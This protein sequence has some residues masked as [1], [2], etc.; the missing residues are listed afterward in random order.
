LFETQRKA[1]ANFRSEMHYKLAT[2]LS[3]TG[4]FHYRYQTVSICPEAESAQNGSIM[5]A[6]NQAFYLAD[7]KGNNAMLFPI[8]HSIC[9]AVSFCYEAR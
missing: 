7:R 1:S 6:G 8:V 5:K 9:S 2:R 4:E 3:I